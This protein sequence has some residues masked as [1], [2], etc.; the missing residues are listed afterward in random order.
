MLGGDTPIVSDEIQAAFVA[1]LGE[2]EDGEVRLIPEALFEASKNPPFHNHRLYY[3]DRMGFGSGA[4]YGA[5]MVG[6]PDQVLRY[7]GNKNA[8]R[9]GLPSKS[10]DTLSFHA[11]SED[12]SLS[13]RYF[14]HEGEELAPLYDIR[15]VD[16][17]ILADGSGPRSAGMLDYWTNIRDRRDLGEIM[18]R[19]GLKYNPD[20]GIFEVRLGDM[21]V[22]ALSHAPVHGIIE[23]YFPEEL[24]NDPHEAGIELDEWARADWMKDFGVT[25]IREL[26]AIEEVSVF[27]ATKASKVNHPILII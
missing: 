9:I 12:L 19:G 11:Q 15:L 14:P 18:Q 1:K 25:W 5:E 16:K 3:N 2:R 6:L 27:D 24:Q 4:F 17:S 21:V 22:K 8:M 26:V 13:L 23:S 10:D 7:F 20:T